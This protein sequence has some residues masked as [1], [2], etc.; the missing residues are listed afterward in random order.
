MDICLKC[1]EDF[2]IGKFM[3]DV[4]ELTRCQFFFVSVTI[5]YYPDK[6]EKELDFNTY[7]TEINWLIRLLIKYSIKFSFEKKNGIV[8]WIP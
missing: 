8:L 6:C 5:S 7:V 4:A 3:A 1:N 2:N